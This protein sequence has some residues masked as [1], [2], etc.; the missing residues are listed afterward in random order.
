M[1]AICS[2]MALALLEG[3]GCPPPRPPLMDMPIVVT[4]YYPELGGINCNDDC[5]VLAD[6]LPWDD[7][8]YG[9]VAACPH[10]LFYETIVIPGIGPLLCRDTGPAVKAV[11]H[12]A[13]KEWVFFVDI[14]EKPG[15][16]KY[17][18]HIFYEWSIK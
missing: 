2:F 12:D 8:D 16:S 7:G 3:I 14:L 11:L 1:T 10:E 4:Y 6:N 17:N 18:Q 5:G 9:R 13:Y 15:V